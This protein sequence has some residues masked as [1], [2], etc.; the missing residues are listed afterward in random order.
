MSYTQNSLLLTEKYQVVK[1]AA[2]TFTF[3]EN[4]SELKLELNNFDHDLHMPNIANSAPVFYT[5]GDMMLNI[6]YVW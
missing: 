1:E 6:L 4:V 5:N 2:G 3:H